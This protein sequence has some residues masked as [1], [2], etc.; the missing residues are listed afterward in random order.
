MHDDVL[1]R[2]FEIALELALFLTSSHCPAG[3]F[4]FESFFGFFSLVAL[5]GT[6]RWA[7]LFIIYLTVNVVVGEF[8]R[9]GELGT[10]GCFALVW[11]EHPLAA[12]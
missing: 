10:L 12:N 8:D 1:W 2:L 6:V 7:A 4:S 3:D 11:R 9:F 5:Y